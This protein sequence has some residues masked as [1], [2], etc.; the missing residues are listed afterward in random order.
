MYITAELI[1]ILYEVRSQMGARNQVLDGSALPPPR[2]RGNFGGILLAHCKVRRVTVMEVAD[3]L[4][5]LQPKT[6]SVEVQTP[7][8]LQHR[9]Y[10]LL[11]KQNKPQFLFVVHVSATALKTANITSSYCLLMCVLSVLIR[12]L[13]LMVR[14]TWRLLRKQDT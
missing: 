13:K 6:V 2:G 14:R 1:N 11:Y 3:K 7:K 12:A 5:E 10:C 9:L 8:R 4:G